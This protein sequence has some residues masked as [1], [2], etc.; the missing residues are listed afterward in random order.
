MGIFFKHK[1]ITSNYRIILISFIGFALNYLLNLALMR[2]LMPEI[3]GLIAVIVSTIDMMSLID[4]LRFDQLFYNRPEENRGIENFN[5]LLM[6]S[7][8]IPLILILSV[9]FYFISHPDRSVGPIF[10]VFM[11]LLIFNKFL[12][13]MLSLFSLESTKKWKR[14]RFEGISTLIG[15]MG[16]LVALMMA[17]CGFSYWSL[18]VKY[19]LSSFIIVVYMAWKYPLNLKF[20]VDWSICRWYLSK[21][22]K[23]FIN[24]LVSLL[25]GRLDDLVI[26]YGIS[27]A[28]LGVYSK[29]FHFVRLPIELFTNVML[30]NNYPLLI[31]H[32]YN[33]DKIMQIIKV[34]VDLNVIVVGAIMVNLLLVL[35]Y[36]IHVFFGST[37]AS[38]YPLSIGLMFLSFGKPFLDVIYNYMIIV[39][40]F[41]TINLIYIWYGI[42]E[43]LLIGAGFLFFGYWGVT[44]AQSLAMMGAILIIHGY[45][46]FSLKL[47]RNIFGVYGVVLAGF[48]I[49]NY[50]N[51]QPI[52]LHQLIISIA[53]ANIM[54]I[55][56][57]YLI[58]H[59]G[60]IKIINILR[61]GQWNSIE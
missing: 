11:A 22:K 33:S 56:I 45:T 38:I 23:L 17:Y 57:I 40:K 53:C 59:D 50:F 29:A 52:T 28:I 44:I 4:A 10:W 48:I 15:I 26:G 34:L 27:Q 47:I 60:L 5:Y 18:I 30:A 1:I 58:M 7:L 21:G 54:Y 46:E 25:S 8:N 19:M 49:I 43:L 14:Y 2:W 9:P 41:R 36:L 61:T 39:E 16:S 37:W 42:I 35:Y 20:R 13:I 32:R 6:R 3:F 55:I 12:L 51:L 24:N 31:K